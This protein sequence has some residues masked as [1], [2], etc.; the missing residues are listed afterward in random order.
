MV[1]AK[2]SQRHGSCLVAIRD[3]RGT[4][5]FLKIHGRVHDAILVHARLSCPLTMLINTELGGAAGV[6]V[7][8]DCKTSFAALARAAALACGAARHGDA[9]IV[10]AIAPVAGSVKVAASHGHVIEDVVPRIILRL[11]HVGR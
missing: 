5:A 8:A 2:G 11:H 1:V 4:G 6:V 7:A 10:F 9:V 3:D